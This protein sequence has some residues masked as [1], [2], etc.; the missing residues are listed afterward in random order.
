MKPSSSHA[1]GSPAE[2]CRTERRRS[3]GRV[4]GA[5]LALVGGTARAAEQNIVDL[6]SS[7][8]VTVRPE[9]RDGTSRTVAPAYEFL[10]LRA[11]RLKNPYVDELGVFVQGWGSVDLGAE[12]ERQGQGAD[13][14]LA[15]VEGELLDQHLRFRAGRQLVF[16]GV[17]RVSHLDG[18]FATLVA[19]PGLGLSIW[20]G[21]PVTPRRFDVDGGDVMGGARAF[22]RLS[23]DSELGA[24]FH[25]TRD[26]GRTERQEV[27][28]DARALLLRTILLT[29]AAFWNPEE[30]RLAESRLE[31]SWEL[32]RGLAV[33]ARWQRTAPDLL[34]PR[35]SILTVFVADERRD[36]AGGSVSYVPARRWSMY[37]E[38]LRLSGNGA[39]GNLATGRVVFA[40]GRSSFGAE[41]RELDYADDAQVTPRVFAMVRPA[42]ALL[43]SADLAATVLDE[44]VNGQDW[45]ITSTGNAAW[46]FAPGWRAVLGLL[47][48]R[49]PFFSRRFEVVARLEW[50][51][52]P[53]LGEWTP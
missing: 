46:A 23:A 26:G 15:Y 14:N 50:S 31:A 41:V 37:A 12:R 48:G 30:A 1:S 13:L 4:A 53:G 34:L 51:L 7:S 20:G 22:W 24:S 28:L 52:S 42:R 18:L 17:A 16:G 44:P 6:S 38:Y 27:G 5:C 2:S 36:M 49:S 25:E 32:L 9:A 21:L 10:T 11:K 45:S 29:G 47:G 3:A 8:L 35:D 33:A 43:L 39:S 19:G 40:P